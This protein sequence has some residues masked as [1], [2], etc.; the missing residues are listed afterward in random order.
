MPLLAAAAAAFNLNC[1]VHRTLISM[2]APFSKPIS[3]TQARITYRIDLHAGRWCADD[4][5]ETQPVAGVQD[6]LILLK[7]RDLSDFA[8]E[9]IS[10]NRES[11]AYSMR[12]VPNVLFSYASGQC[13]RAPFT[14]LPQPR[15]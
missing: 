14:G 9:E 15:F 3:E 7:A 10:I 12:G 5:A 4:C 13:E 1:S 11:G 6:T 8:S 2:A